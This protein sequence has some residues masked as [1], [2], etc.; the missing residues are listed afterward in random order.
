MDLHSIL[1]I[2]ASTKTSQSAMCS[3]VPYGN[4]FQVEM[5]LFF[6]V[7]ELCPCLSHTNS[8][9]TNSHY[10]HY[11]YRWNNYMPLKKTI[12]SYTEVNSQ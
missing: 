2:M 3:T 7:S 6:C 8:Q 4:G 11:H 9:L 12:S 1:Y 10:L 5:Y